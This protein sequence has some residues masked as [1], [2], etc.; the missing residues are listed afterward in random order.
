MSNDFL[1]ISPQPECVCLAAR[2]YPDFPNLRLTGRKAILD[3]LRDWS[4]RGKP[5]R[6]AILLDSVAESAEARSLLRRLA[7]Q[8]FQI[9]WVAGPECASVQEACRDASN[10]Q[11]HTG[12]T[13]FAAFNAAFRASAKMKPLMRQAANRETDLLD[14]IN[15]K[16]SLAMMRSMDAEPV[17]EAVRELRRCKSRRFL[18]ENL[19]EEDRKSLEHFRREDFPY[20]AG[21]TP[22]LN[23]MKRDILRVAPS[24]L[25]VLILGETGTGKENAAFYLHEFSARRGGPFIA[26]NCAGLDEHFLRS[27]LFGHKKGAFTGALQDQRGLVTEAEGGTLFLDE[28]GD[29]PPSVQADLL[30]FLQT[31]RYRPLGD[32]REISAD[33]RIIAATQPN[34]HIKKR[35]G[36]FREDLYY[37]IAEFELTTPPLR[38]IPVD[39]HR[40]ARHII[41]HQWE[42]AD[43]EDSPRFQDAL[44]YFSANREL[45]ERY[46]WPGNVRELAAVVRRKIELNDECLATLGAQPEAPPLP[47]QLIP[48]IERA[49]DIRTLREVQRSYA[50]HAAAQQERLGLT[51]QELARRLKIHVATLNKLLRGKDKPR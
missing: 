49:S 3:A 2:I 47:L 34:L 17:A 21:H 27:E 12:D 42:R 16:I 7:K 51:Q 44:D 32:T 43:A 36:E 4:E 6:A 33:I 48:A 22:P 31:R 14:F 24:E 40:V 46:A 45:M 25:S 13:L 18:L 9:I 39:I 29:M 37:R 5:G 23:K 26:L 15:Y 35:N 28:I 19:S 38:E 1:A 41:Y 30:R 50:E 20:I 8:D 10:V 11:L